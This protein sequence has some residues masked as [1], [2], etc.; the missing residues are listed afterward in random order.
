MRTSLPSATAVPTAVS[1]TG[2]ES[3]TTFSSPRRPF[4]KGVG[5]TSKIRMKV[6]EVEGCAT[7]EISPLNRVWMQFP[8]EFPLRERFSGR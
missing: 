1:A 2:S 5:M 7:P 8:K 3:Q 4:S 6:S